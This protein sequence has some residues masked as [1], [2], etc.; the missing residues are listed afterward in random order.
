VGLA[1][2]SHIFSV[3]SSKC[4]GRKLAAV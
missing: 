3:V 2:V 4:A 1:R